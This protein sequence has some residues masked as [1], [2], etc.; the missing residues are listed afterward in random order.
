MDQLVSEFNFGIPTNGFKKFGTGAIE[1]LF[2][3]HYGL[4]NK[5]VYCI[6]SFFIDVKTLSIIQECLYHHSP[7]LCQLITVTA[8]NS[9]LMLV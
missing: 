5:G 8:M 9:C 4:L 3:F 7:V 1:F 2:E 6:L